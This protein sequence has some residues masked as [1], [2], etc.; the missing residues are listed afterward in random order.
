[1]FS[2]RT[3]LEANTHVNAWVLTCLFKKSLGTL[4]Y[5]SHVFFTFLCALLQGMP[6]NN[7]KRE[8]IR[9]SSEI[10]KSFANT[11]ALTRRFMSKSLWSLT[12]NEMISLNMI[13]KKRMWADLSTSYVDCYPFVVCKP[14]IKKFIY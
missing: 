8:E 5:E 12:I 1:M 4:K 6:K 3:T 13:P 2:K 7:K 11:E 10:E 9:G 14:Y